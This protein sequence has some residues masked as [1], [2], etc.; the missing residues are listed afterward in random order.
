VSDP[1][2]LE[3][4]DVSIVFKTPA[5]Q[6]VAVER[7]SLSLASGEALGLIG[8]SG[9]GK[10]TLA[11][12]IVGLV[13]PASGNVMLEGVRVSGR[14]R[15][16]SERRAIQMVFQDPFSSLNPRLSIRSVLSELL[17]VHAL[18][19]HDAIEA[20]LRELMGLVGLP[21]AALDA[22]PVAFSGG[23][24]QRIAIARALAVEPRMLIADEPTS[25]LDVSVQA[26]VLDLFADIRTRLQVALLFVSHDLAIVRQLCDR[27]AVLYFSEIVEIGPRDALFTRPAHPYTRALLAAAPHLDGRVEASAHISGELPSPTARP[28]GCAFRARCPRAEQICAEV[29][30]QLEP[31]VHEPDRQAACHFREKLVAS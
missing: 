24:R 15:S 20:R 30:P 4:D 10:T 26:S 29:A 14:R 25:A 5:G 16:R 31:L 18:V 21:P 13:E 12:A 2:L 6:L 22:R 23:Q 28:S 19:P 9:S 11:R 3:V 17:T 8:E 1:P 27:V 7:V